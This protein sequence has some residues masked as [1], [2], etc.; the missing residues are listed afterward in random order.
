MRFI[1]TLSITI[2]I[3]VYYCYVYQN[4]YISEH[5]IHIIS[6]SIVT[7]NDEYHINNK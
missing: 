4:L 3:Q 7:L 1:K 5:F 6:V 2:F